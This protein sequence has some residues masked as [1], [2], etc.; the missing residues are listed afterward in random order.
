MPRASL[1]TRDEWRTECVAAAAPAR[2]QAARFLPPSVGAT[3]EG[4]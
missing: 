2:Y 4:L 1:V 3:H